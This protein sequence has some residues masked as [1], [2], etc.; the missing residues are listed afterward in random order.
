VLH[1][2]LTG[3]PVFPKNFP[4]AA[5]PAHRRLVEL[6][7]AAAPDAV[8]AVSALDRPEPIFDDG[9]L[10]FPS[11]TVAPDVGRFLTTGAHVELTLPAGVLEGEG[12]NVSGRTGGSGSRAVVCAHIDSKPTTP[13]AVD[14]AGGVAA[15]LALA[16]SR[17]LDE[18]PVEFV[19]FN[20]ED[21]YAAPGEQA[22]LADTDLSEIDLCVNLD[23]AGFMGSR[24]TICSMSC[25]EET[26]L[27]VE[28]VA[29]ASGLLPIEPWVQSDH[30]VFAL[31]GIPSIALTSEISEGLTSILHT[32]SDVRTVVDPHSLA[33][34]ADAVARILSASAPP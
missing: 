29:A 7:E 23:G 26:S 15:L 28:R 16:G 2:S 4:F 10:T 27:L 30:A 9:D 8:V 6:L 24:T 3:E 13:G 1:G 14:N 5:F 33:V 25:S 19:F 34:A 32:D 11:T 20:G 31:K 22:W 21:H 18:V 17:I 12:V